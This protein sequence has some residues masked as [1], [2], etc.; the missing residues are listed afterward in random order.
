MHRAAAFKIGAKFDNKG[1][2]FTYRNYKGVFYFPADPR[3]RISKL[4][5]G[6][7]PVS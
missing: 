5:D 3:V 4:F 7:F 2:G 1:G 6:G